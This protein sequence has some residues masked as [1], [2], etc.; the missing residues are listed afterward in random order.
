MPELPE[1]ECLRRT[2]EP[3]LVA[4][5]IESVSVRR[6]SFVEAAGFATRPDKQA[7]R[8]APLLGATIERLER[9]GKELAIVEASSGRSLRVR[10]GMTGGMRIE[11]AIRLPPPLP[12]EHV[13][14][15][16]ESPLGS[17][18]LR[19]VDPRRFGDLV[20]YPDHETL[21]TDRM[22]RLGPDGLAHSAH[23]LAERLRPRLAGTSRSVKVA[24]L[25]QSVVAGLGNIYADESL[26]SAG[27]SP[28]RE[29]CSLDRDEVFRL[30]EAIG[31]V[32][33][34][35][36]RRGGSTLRDY[37]DAQGRAGSAQE[38]HQAYGR[39][40]LPCFRC[41]NPL[42]GANLGGRSTAFCRHCQ[43]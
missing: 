24:L 10:L 6:R 32:L 26:F 11:P 16:L 25:D 31:A 8:G 43:H 5:R 13:R 3:V 15:T 38:S 2:L 4:A 36:V 33:S 17:F 42:S 23:D 21:R 34:A 41:G 40:G 27:V 18:L 35:A 37:R 9:H 1:V 14:W 7:A 29:A 20:V 28:H 39:A 12:H 30:A 22:R 19:H